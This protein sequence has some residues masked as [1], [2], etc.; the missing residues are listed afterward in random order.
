MFSL[1]MAAG[2]SFEPGS[3]SAEYRMPNQT[4]PD[5]R[6]SSLTEKGAG[7]AASVFGFVKS[8]QPESGRKYWPKVLPARILG[9]IAA[10][11]M[12][13]IGL[14]LILLWE[15]RKHLQEMHWRIDTHAGGWGD[16]AAFYI[17]I[18]IGIWSIL[19]L[20]AKCRQIGL[21]A[22]RA[23]NLLVLGL[24][25]IF[26]VLGFHSGDR[27]YLYLVTGR[28]LGWN[29][30]TP[31]LEMKFLFGPP[32]LGFWIFGY[33]LIYYC[34]ARTGYERIMLY[35]TAAVG[36]AFALLYLCELMQYREELLVADCLGLIWLLGGRMKGKPLRVGWL[37]VPL[38]GLVLLWELFRRSTPD[39]MTLSPAFL[40]LLLICIVL[41][42]GA[43]VIAGRYEFRQ[44]WFALLPFCLCSFLLLT[45]RHYPL[46]GNY[47]HLL[48][49]GL[50]LPH[51]F[52]GSLIIIV[53]VALV[54]AVYGRFWPGGPLWW[55][56]AVNW[57]FI[58]LTF[59][60]LR[61]V[62]IM[63]VRVEWDVLALA[64]SPKMAW[65]MARPYVADAAAV[66][67]VAT[68]IYILTVKLV[69][70]LLLRAS[71]AAAD[72]RPSQGFRCAMITFIAFAILGSFLVKPDKG[73]GQAGLLILKTSPIWKRAALRPMNREEFLATTEKL[74]LGDPEASCAPVS[75]PR[76]DLNV[77][78]VFMESSYNQHLS[79]FGSSEETQPLMAKYKDRMEIFP[80]FFSN[81]A[82]SIHAR[83]ASFT[84]L[85]PTED[86]NS[87]TLRRVPVKSIFEVLNENGYSCSIFDSSFFD[88]TGFRDFLNQR[89][90]DEM[91]DA[92]SMPGKRTTPPV[93]WGLR[94]VETLGA[95]QAQI[96]RYAAER[97]RF[98]LTYIP[99]APHYPYDS[100]PAQFNTFKPG[101]LGDYTPLYLNA[102]VYM[103]WVISSIVGQL[104]QSG[105]LEHTLVIITNDHGEMLGANGGPIGHGWAITPE[106]V[107]TPLIIMD[108]ERTGARVNYAFGSQI[109]LLPTIL[110]RLHIA[111]PEGQLYQGQSLDQP[112]AGRQP[113]I[114]L[115][116]YQEY[117]LLID[118]QLM[119]GD[120]TAAR[121][122]CYAITNENTRTIFSEI[123]AQKTPD[124]SI[125]RFSEFQENFLRHYSLYCRCVNKRGS[126][127]TQTKVE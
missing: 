104:Q 42:A 6:E 49:L 88:Y 39:L 99:A 126:T 48:C 41:F 94:E 19:E 118:H 119:I 30:L 90:L 77:L 76:R 120:R 124:I 85:Y 11:F 101:Q 25:L 4:T 44:T 45:N 27:N 37:L 86:F 114:Y 43:T 112:P 18:L 87:F 20:A 56:D 22:L 17:F 96:K 107:N 97:K 93:S 14:K 13:L 98:F 82:G 121:T 9:R 69:R 79:L 75:G 91:Y 60:D 108:P 117:A 38:G 70:R 67:L 125:K 33:G 59:L 34:L 106:L 110:D 92:E 50:Q 81:F 83:F 36:A 24:G 122:Q 89:G 1:R 105:L 58:A 21:R 102:L 74:G 113:W 47:N 65:R 12:F 23:A 32:F 127:Q 53:V 54:A 55:L 2:Q 51:Y 109:D 68:L 63:G 35:V 80:N 61:V 31:Y 95:I 66:L 84:S 57:L 8:L 29:D 123:P 3:G 28:I 40:V 115:N 71:S 46:A 111:I 7:L 5:T 16:Y 15:L 64:N 103:D 73:E 78:L 100:T 26:I 62:E 52:A 116:S 10:L 72:P